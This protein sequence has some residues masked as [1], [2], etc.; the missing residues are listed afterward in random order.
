MIQKEEERLRVS[1]DRALRLKAIVRGD[2]KE[3]NNPV[4]EEDDENDAAKSRSIV[5]EAGMYGEDNDQEEDEEMA[6]AREI[7]E[8]KRLEADEMKQDFADNSETPV[9]TSD[10]EEDDGGLHHRNSE[11][12]DEVLS[13]KNK[14]GDLLLEKF[15]ISES[16]K[17]TSESQ[18]GDLV[19]DKSA[20]TE[21]EDGALVLSKNNKKGPSDT[22]PLEVGEENKAESNQVEVKPKDMEDDGEAEF[23]ETKDLTLTSG[24]DS[25]RPRNAGWKAMLEKEA[26]ILKRQKAR[27]RSS[28]VDA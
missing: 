22:D 23:D 15:E 20:N 13:E 3:E 12:T 1:R 9:G 18:D 24:K 10:R 14:D 5:G 25:N 11:T 28:I 19:L 8:Q 16:G 2:E 26:L 6:L 27:G 21:I 17:V 4:E 7:E